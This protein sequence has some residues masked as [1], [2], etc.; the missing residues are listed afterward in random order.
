[1]ELSPEQAG[2]ALRDI[3]RAQR[4]LGIFSGYR[5]AAPHLWMWGLIWIAGYGATDLMPQVAGWIWLVLNVGGMAIGIAIGRHQMR[6][7][8]RMRGEPDGDVTSMRMIGISVAIVIFIFATFDMLRQQTPAQFGA[9]PVLLMGL[10]YAL[11][12]LWAGL[13]WSIV[14]LVLS[15]VSM[16]GYHFIV[17]H[18]MLWLGAAGGGT[19]ILSGFW[20]RVR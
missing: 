9:F 15:A 8:A 12:G 11:A 3:A 19:L 18:Y 17:Q 5:Y 4:R 1:M 10:L 13:R 6:T 2:S 14:G 20:M 7:E 16:L